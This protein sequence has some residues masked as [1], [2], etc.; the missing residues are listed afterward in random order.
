[1]VT[2]IVTVKKQSESRSVLS[3]KFEMS[4]SE[5]R[6]RKVDTKN[7]KTRILMNESEIEMRWE[8]ETNECSR[9]R[10]TEKRKV[11]SIMQRCG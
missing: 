3:G 9:G 1:M 4:D 8:S 7:L 2:V 6:V 5:M 10:K 11:L